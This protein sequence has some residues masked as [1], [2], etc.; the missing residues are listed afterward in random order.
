MQPGDQ[1]PQLT[2]ACVNYDSIATLHMSLISG[3]AFLLQC[4]I[5]SDI[6]TKA[7]GTETNQTHHHLVSSQL[8]KL[9]LD[10]FASTSTNPNKQ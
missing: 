6:H 2:G 1:L 9:L 3:A 7:R 10:Y 5:Q 4:Q 8:N